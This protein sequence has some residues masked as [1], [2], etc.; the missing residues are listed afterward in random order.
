MNLKGIYD[1]DKLVA[2][3]Q[4]REASVTE[5]ITSVLKNPSDPTKTFDHL[6][7]LC[8][9]RRLKKPAARLRGLRPDRENPGAGRHS[10]CD[11]GQHGHRCRLGAPRRVGFAHP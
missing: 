11:Q 1:D 7:T 9:T 5:V 8:P 2:L 3:Y 10:C 6:L 4:K